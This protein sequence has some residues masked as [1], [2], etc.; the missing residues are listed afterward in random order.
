MKI[1]IDILYENLKDIFELEIRG[2]RPKALTLRHIEFFTSSEKLREDSIYLASCDMLDECAQAFAGMSFICFGGTPGWAYTQRDGTLLIIKDR[3]GIVEVFHS[4]QQVF[5]RYEAWEDELIEILRTTANLLDMVRVSVP[6][7]CNPI[8]I[9]D[10]Q[11]NMLARTLVQRDKEGNVASYTVEHMNAIFTPEILRIMQTDHPRDKKKKKPYFYKDSRYC[12]NLFVHNRFVVNMQL[13]SFIRP[14]LPGDLV[15]FEFFSG[16][17]VEALHKYTKVLSNRVH[18]RKSMLQDILEQKPINQNWLQQIANSDNADPERFVCFKMQLYG[19]SYALPSE[20]VCQALEQVLPGCVAFEHHS[21]ILAFLSMADCPFSYE[22]S[23]KIFARF[24]EDMD[25]RA[26][27]SDQ[28][29]D[30][31]NARQYYLQAECAIETGW[32]IHPDKQYY[33]F[34]DYAVSYMLKHCV[35]KMEVEFLCPRGLVKLRERGKSNSGDYW[36]TLRIYLENEMNASL[37]AKQLFLHRSTL[38]QKLTRIYS[39]LDVDISDPV[40]RLYVQLCMSLMDMQ[41]KEF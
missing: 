11:Y 24:L 33:L 34:E 3:V 12:I 16:L 13:V 36:E 15:L 25:F 27:V 14:F 30:I 8:Q 28:F 40:K 29:E 37:T 17:V 41:A 7:F 23:L 31:Q 9:T 39:I 38:V 18:T 32:E 22:D 19:D 35:G 6:I 4:V 20:A 10:H 1:N 21:V 26:G 2:V 5:L